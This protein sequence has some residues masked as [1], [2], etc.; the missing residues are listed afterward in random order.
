MTKEKFVEWLN[1]NDF[2]ATADAVEQDDF[3]AIERRIEEKKRYGYAS[4]S[5]VIRRNCLN[6]L[7]NYL[8][9]HKLKLLSN[10]R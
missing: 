7:I 1:E 6:Y 5:K 10:E 9:K 3:K 2:G 8:R 4:D